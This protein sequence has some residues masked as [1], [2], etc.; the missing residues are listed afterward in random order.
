MRHAIVTTARSRLMPLATPRWADTLDTWATNPAITA[1][2][3][4]MG[5]TPVIREPTAP[6]T[7]IAHIIHLTTVD[8][9]LPFSWT[10]T[11]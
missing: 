9:N 7:V 11:L 10:K 3:M 5:T 6:R 4:P 8:S 1:T 2:A